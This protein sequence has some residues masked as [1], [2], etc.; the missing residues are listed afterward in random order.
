MS[1][2]EPDDTFLDKATNVDNILAQIKDVLKD[3]R[4]EIRNIEPR[5]VSDRLVIE[6]GVPRESYQLEMS[7][8][9]E[10]GDKTSTTRTV[11]FDGWVDGFIVGFPDG[12]DQ[13]VGL[14]LE[15][16]DT[17]EQ[18]FPRNPEDRY[19]AANAY[20]DNLDLSFEVEEGQK[21]T[22]E[23]RNNDSMNEHFVNAMVTVKRKEDGE[24]V[25]R[26]N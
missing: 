19:F 26:G 8:L 1:Q 9:V 22:A 23:L 18:Y 14:R 4:D 7:S 5:I 15:D 25:T 13:A 21:L 11:P 10:E 6:E 12:A 24:V 20:S 17:G 16:D 3:V 2:G